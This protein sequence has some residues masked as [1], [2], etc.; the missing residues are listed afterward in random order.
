[1]S[2]DLHDF[3][4]LNPQSLHM[5][6]ELADLLKAAGTD[7]LVDLLMSMS[8]LQLQREIDYAGKDIQSINDF[9]QEIVGRL[10]V[11]LDE[12]SRRGTFTE[13]LH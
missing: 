9:W 6:D 2:I 1:M 8:T 4:K 3:S 13:R 10:V 5:L 12:Q 11:L 7:R